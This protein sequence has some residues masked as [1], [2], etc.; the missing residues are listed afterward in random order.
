MGGQGER[1]IFTIPDFPLISS[2]PSIKGKCW[3]SYVCV[4][5]VYLCACVY[6]F[7]FQIM[8]LIQAY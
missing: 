1:E 6:V 5:C 7:F 8:H 2:I 3:F 4:I